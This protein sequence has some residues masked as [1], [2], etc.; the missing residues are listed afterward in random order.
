MDAAGIVIGVSGVLGWS[1]DPLL[2]MCLL[3]RLRG[4]TRSPTPVCSPTV[5]IPEAVVSVVS[6]V[7]GR[8]MYSIP[9]ER[10]DPRF[11]TVDCQRCIKGTSSDGPPTSSQISTFLWK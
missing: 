1:L 7:L 6:W 4:L 8:H 3:R 10:T 5:Y 11:R 9:R 2:A